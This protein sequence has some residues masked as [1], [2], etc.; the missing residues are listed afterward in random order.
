MIK[1]AV[2]FTIIGLGLLYWVNNRYF[3]PIEG[4]VPF[5]STINRKDFSGVTRLEIIPSDAGKPFS[6]TKT[7]GKWIIQKGHLNFV[8]PLVNVE[9][10]LATLGHLE[11]DSIISRKISDQEIFGVDEE[12][13]IQVSLYQEGT[14]QDAFILGSKGVN[15]FLRIPKYSEIYQL[16]PS[17]L[18]EASFLFSSFRDHQ[19]ITYDPE[20][21]NEIR[22]LGKD[23]MVWTKDSVGWDSLLT[24]D[25]DELL[26]KWSQI[27]MT[28][29][30]DDFDETN[31]E[32]VV[33]Q[34]ELIGRQQQ[35]VSLFCYIDTLHESPYVLHSTTNSENWFL[36]DSTGVYLQIFGVLMPR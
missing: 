9:K 6:L 2:F 18:Q 30:A 14:I 32:W 20:S 17:D 19:L 16:K 7:D 27:K 35:V 29:F 23:T 36:S 22:L 24:I 28:D 13:G 8:V 12:H 1:R 10:M 15:H 33:Q 26:K 3:E 4:A 5:S 21:I 31:E 34:L 25:L 11:S